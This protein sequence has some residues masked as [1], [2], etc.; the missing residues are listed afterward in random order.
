VKVPGWLNWVILA[1][2]VVVVV[3]VLLILFTGVGCDVTG[4]E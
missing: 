2:L 1:A 4:T 3:W